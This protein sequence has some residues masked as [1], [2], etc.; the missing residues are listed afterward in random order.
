MSYTIELPQQDI[1]SDSCP[2]RARCRVYRTSDFT[3]DSGP[4]RVL[5][6]T[7]F[8]RTNMAESGPIS[9]EGVID[10]ILAHFVMLWVRVVYGNDKSMYQNR[11]SRHV[12]KRLEGLGL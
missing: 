9:G 3:P 11:V 1:W 7:D 2:N 6:G 10:Q 5:G 8:G 4:R 12:W